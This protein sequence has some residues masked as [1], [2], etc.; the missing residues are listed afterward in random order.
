MRG[1][2]VHLKIEQRL[3]SLEVDYHRL[4]TE[5]A[6]SE[7][8]L[9]SLGSELELQYEKLA[10]VYL[11][12]LDREAA[13]LT[14]VRFPKMYGRVAILLAEKAGERNG[15]EEEQRQLRESRV[16]LDSEFD[17][18]TGDVET[19]VVE[20]NALQRTVER[21]LMES[22]RFLELKEAV[23]KARKNLDQW[24]R[25]RQRATAERENKL[26]AY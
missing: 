12:R 15:L 10:R 22:A 14:Q 21:E 17:R 2:H 4:T 6:D 1:E 8:R 13:V 16:K 9:Q 24:N 25:R 26:P 3:R 11:P 18:V 5:I 19:K 7:R 20:R 23:D